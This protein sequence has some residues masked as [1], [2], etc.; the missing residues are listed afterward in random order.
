MKPTQL[1]ELFA[2]I[3]AT[4]VSFFSIVMF[5]ALGV[6]IFT[7][8]FWMRPALQNT[9][10]HEFENGNLHHFQVQF[11]YGLTDDDLAKLGE[12]DGVS[13]VEAVRQSFQKVSAKDTTYTVKVQSLP[14]DMDKLHVVEGDLPTSSD[15]IAL[16]KELAKTLGISVGDSI[17][18]SADAAESDGTGSAP[19][20]SEGAS[21]KRRAMRYLNAQEYRVSG[22][23]DSA[24]Y[25]AVSSQSLGV[26][27][28]GSGSTDGVA[29]VPKDAF[30]ASAFRDGWPV[31][32]VACSSLKDLDTFSAAYADRSS[33]IED[34]IVE[35]GDTLADAR[36][37]DLHDSAQAQ[38]DDAEKKLAEGRRQIDE[39]EEQLQKGK[40]E[41]ADGERKIA[42]GEKELEDGKK[43]VSEAEE[44]LETGRK[45][46][47]E[48]TSAAKEQ[49][50]QALETIENAQAQYD[51]AVP[52]LEEA[53]RINDALQAVYPTAKEAANAALGLLDSLAGEIAELDERYRKGELSASEYEESAIRAYQAYKLEYEAADA[54]IGEL[55][56]LLDGAKTSFPDVEIRGSIPRLPSIPDL[57][58]SPDGADVQSL[59]R[60]IDDAMSIARS[61]ID[62][63]KAA[64]IT[65]EGSSLSF[66]TSDTDVPAID[67]KVAEAEREASSKKEELDA[68]IETYN[69]AVAEYDNES[70]QGMEKLQDAE[71]QIAEGKEKIEQSEHEL[72]D[73]RTKAADGK[74]QIEEKSAQLEDAKKQLA[75]KSDELEKSKRTLGLMKDYRWTVYPRKY[76]GAVAEADVLG[77]VMVNLAYSMAA[78]FVIVG[79][80]VSYSAV[81]RIV[82]EQV[83]LIGTKKALGLRSREIT[84]SFL[85]YSG[86]AVVAGSVL[87]LLVAVLVVQNIVGGS[88]A[89]R[90]VLDR[91]SPYFGLP[92]ALFATGVE[93]L[94][95]LGATWFACRTAL[96]EHAVELLKGAKPP[97]GKTHF[98]EKWKIWD[99]LPL[100]TQTIVNNCINDKRRVFSTIVGVAGCTA[101][102]VTAVT[103]NNNVLNSYDMHYRN[104]YGFDTIVYANTGKE[105]SAERVA[106]KLEE[107]GYECA[108][109]L[110]T[111]QALQLSGGDRSMITLVVPSDAD[112]FAS[113]YHVNPVSA[114]EATLSEEGIWISRAY[115]SHMGAK[116]GDELVINASDGAVHRPTIAGFYEFYLSFN[117]AVIGRDAYESVFLS[118]Y[119]PNAVFVKRGQASIDDLKSSLSGTEGFDRI[120]DDKSSQHKVFADFEKV[121][122]TVVL[123]YLALSILM[124]I[125]GLLNLNVMFIDEKKRELIVLMINGFS[126]KDAKR[127]IYQDT[128][129]LS[130]IGIA[131]GL[132]LGA[133][134]GSLTVGAV[135]TS[136]AFFYK[137]VDPIALV[138]A[139]GTSAVLAAVMSFIAL[140][141]IPAFDLTDINRF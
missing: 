22:L 113:L 81:S 55:N 111:R 132:V 124:A 31:V 40:E 13:G 128:V 80:L 30:D 130:A 8:I 96:R 77:T 21:D 19:T 38:V 117:E 91:I 126:V 97:T 45:E 53:R 58:A 48:K 133:V 18:F 50:D 66:N 83:A 86:V 109:V 63:A 61:G 75:E 23:V 122:H 57:S 33:E 112:R 76:N 73:A 93:L 34:R 11:P 39:G 78:L 28:G 32:N 71:K 102:V 16:R 134:M 100:Y 120:V 60:Q 46:Y 92:L 82:H 27:P 70:A 43:K 139:A 25:L 62:A 7:G 84:V 119:S 94:L 35:L 137:G 42:D 135:E 37:K 44:K 85:L 47:D 110:R 49:L 56:T 79:L 141:R 2:N 12:L 90:F 116:A 6:G 15:Q 121:S 65:V 51:E 87:G 74:K 52:K 89:Q 69:Q 64:S 72:D 99:R 115:E 9:L 107:N 4:F 136:T 125:V 103:L 1:A 101:L 114:G 108:V 104:V 138:V 26:A 17:A 59:K 24:E 98:F 41:L 88:V 10:E 68:G 123:V 95:V 36:F 29:W 20:G 105:D 129:V 67:Q 54:A 106:E 118:T 3:K 14:E 127:Y 140:R 131:V 5:V